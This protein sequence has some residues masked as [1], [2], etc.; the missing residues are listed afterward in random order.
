M[1][2]LIGVVSVIIAVD[3]FGILLAE[4]LPAVRSRVPVD[5]ETLRVLTGH[6]LV[7]ALFIFLACWTCL[8]GR[9]K[10]KANQTVDE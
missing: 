9:R 7:T 3:T 5:W 8:S 4:V 1:R 2:T 6:G 10:Q